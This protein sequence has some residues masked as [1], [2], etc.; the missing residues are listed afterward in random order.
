MFITAL[1]TKV[2]TWNQPKC[3]SMINWTG[4]M[5]HLYTMEYYAAITKNELVS[6]LGTWMNL[7]SII[8]SNL[9]QERKIKHH[10]FS[11][12]SGS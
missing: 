7:E 1:F 2:K 3:P 4:K 11:P 10:V 6:F 9:T 8:L 5:W 12:V